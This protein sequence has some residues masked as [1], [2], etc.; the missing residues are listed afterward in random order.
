MKKIVGLIIT[1]ILADC[2]C[3]STPCQYTCDYEGRH[4][5]LMECVQ[6]NDIYSCT[7]NAKALFC[8]C[9]DAPAGDS[10]GE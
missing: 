9:K 2:T 8:V 10:E 1:L 4:D 3:E 6:Y 7:S 5:W